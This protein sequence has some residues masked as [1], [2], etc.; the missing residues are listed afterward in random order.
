MKFPHSLLLSVFRTQCV[1]LRLNSPIRAQTASF[2]TFL[3]HTQLDTHT[4][5]HP[6]GLIWKKSARRRGRYLYNRQQ[7]QQTNIYALSGIRTHDPSNQAAADQRHT[8]ARSS[9]SKLPLR[10]YFMNYILTFFCHTL[11]KSLHCVA[12]IWNYQCWAEIC[13][14]RINV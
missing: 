9:G 8:P 5:A 11:I 1:F 6:V 3:Y 7:T 10:L 2:F 4:H 12:Y 14:Q 13:L